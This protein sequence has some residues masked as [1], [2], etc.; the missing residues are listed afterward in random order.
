MAF[1]GGQ[2]DRSVLIIGSGFSG[3][4]LAIRLKQ[5]GIGDFLVLER[6]AS[7]GGTWRDNRYPGCAC[8]VQSHL[9]SFSFE[10]NPDWTRMFARQPEIEA[11][12]QRCAEKYQVLPHLQFNAE[13]VEAIYDEAAALWRVRCADGR[14]Y[15]ARALVSAIGPLSR[16]AI[17]QLPGLDRFAGQR[18]HSAQWNHQYDLSDKR[19]A[20]I[21][22]G[23][24]AIQFVPQ[25]A[26]KVARLDL[27]QRTPPWIMRKPDRPI[28]DVERRMFRRFPLLQKL[29]RAALY[30]K[31]ETRV[32]AFVL[33]PWLMKLVQLSA[34]R[35][36]RRQVPD[37]A[38]RRKLTPDYTIGCKRILIADDYYPAVSRGNVEVITDGVRELRAHSIVDAQG[39]ERA[40]DAIIFGTGFAVHE[41]VPRGM[42]RGRDG[43]DLWEVWQQGSEAYL[44]TTVSGFPN[45]FVLLGPNTGLGHSSQVYMIEAQIAYVMDALRQM[46]QRGWRAVDVRREVQDRYN[47]GIQNEVRKAIWTAGGCKSWYLNARGRNT[48]L[49]PGFTFMFRKR[50]QRFVADDYVC[51]SALQP[52]DVT[53]A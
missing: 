9:Y 42:I 53:P 37:P 3:L 50:T 8:D 39:R 41:M 45:L 43:R 25:I 48:T 14:R 12:L 29:W 16:P 23:A 46:R 28:S 20:V 7:L 5:A 51:E 30:A 17:P 22:T 4:G 2:E 32:L 27:Y 52:A 47:D 49:W 13:V 40:V 26:A 15:T 38:L 31:L 21:G 33:H 36:M 10:L 24:S 18:F 44:G 19:V 35:H 1:D 11:Y 6:G 34:L